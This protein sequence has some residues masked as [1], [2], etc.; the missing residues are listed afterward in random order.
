M[1]KINYLKK[2][3]SGKTFWIS[4]AGQNSEQAGKIPNFIM[5]GKSWTRNLVQ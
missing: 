4:V 5:V 1:L 2:P 3:S